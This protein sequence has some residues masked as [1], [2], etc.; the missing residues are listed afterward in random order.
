MGGASP[1]L[2][3]LAHGDTAL[4]NLHSPVRWECSIAGVGK[5]GQASSQLSEPNEVG[6]HLVYECQELGW[7]TSLALPTLALADRDFYNLPEP[8]E[9]G[10]QFT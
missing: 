5:W 7:G 2:P 6:V 9:G 10:V 1:A 8:S 4:H 3:T